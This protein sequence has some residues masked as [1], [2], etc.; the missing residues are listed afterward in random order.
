MKGT[1]LIQPKNVDVLME[2]VINNHTPL[3]NVLAIDQDNK[4]E[5]TRLAGLEPGA[6]DEEVHSALQEKFTIYF[7]LP[8]E[9]NS[10]IPVEAS[11]E[12]A[13]PA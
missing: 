4:L 2:A 6:S 3:N 7:P 5:L 10:L 12:L 1:I 8:D 13:V 11:E 9:S